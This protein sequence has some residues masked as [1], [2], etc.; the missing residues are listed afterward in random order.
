MQL[1]NGEMPP[2]SAAGA[3]NGLPAPLVQQPI[4]SSLAASAPAG[5]TQAG[6]PG[7]SGA[8]GLEVVAPVEAREFVEGMRRMI[9]S[10]TVKM[11]S[12]MSRGRPLASDTSIQALFNMLHQQQH[13]RLLELIKQ[14]EELRGVLTC[15]FSMGTVIFF[16]YYSSITCF[17][18][19]VY[20]YQCLRDSTIRYSTSPLFK[21]SY[22]YLYFL[23]VLLAHSASI[24]RTSKTRCRKRC[25][26]SCYFLDKI[27]IMF[28][29]LKQLL[30]P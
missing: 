6:A 11:R 19:N 8:A 12:L 1:V 24:L 22:F 10:F 16:F 28:I 7:G 13:P 17:P 3:L 30:I 14:N 21:L 25:L 5:V 27:N 23:R 26:Y 4:A 2:A 15:S 29:F 9:D 20:S 18:S